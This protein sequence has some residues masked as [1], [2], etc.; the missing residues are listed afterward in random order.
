MWDSGATARL[1]LAGVY[2]LNYTSHVDITE[3]HNR[4]K[5]VDGYVDNIHALRYQDQADIAVL[6]GDYPWPSVFS[7]ISGVVSHV[8][9]R[10]ATVDI[11]AM[12]SNYT[13]A[14]EIGHIYGAQHAPDEVL[15]GPSDHSY[16][17]WYNPNPNIKFKDIMAYGK[18]CIP[19]YSCQTIPL[20]SNPSKNVFINGQNFPL[21]SG[22]SAGNCYS[23]GTCSNVALQITKNAFDIANTNLGPCLPWYGIC[24]GVDSSTIKSEDDTVPGQEITTVSVYPNPF[25]D[26]STIQYYIE[27]R[28][29][30]VKINVYDILGRKVISLED[31]FKEKGFHV[32]KWDGKDQ[33]K[34]TVPNG[35]YIY[36]IRIKE[37][38]YTYK[39]ILAK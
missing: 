16:G 34:N 18:N 28:N 7:S 32:V 3:D 17:Y 6:I 5:N 15:F 35:T 23:G 27:D 4:F 20:Y 11:D 25:K 14:H 10:F 8:L 19:Q 39:T 36:T 37:K 31:G 13:F 1:E 38:E 26:S 2:V 30:N 29:S 33:S 24:D 12:Y 9:D 21:G 22:D